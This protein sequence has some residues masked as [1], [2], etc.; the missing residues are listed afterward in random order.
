MCEKLH[1]ISGAFI[2]TIV[3]NI[4]LVM[5]KTCFLVSFLNIYLYN[6]L[7]YNRHNMV[8]ELYYCLFFDLF[9]YSSIDVNC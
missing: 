3:I 4:E 8:H 6:V 7:F 5:D 1:V 9:R 2:F